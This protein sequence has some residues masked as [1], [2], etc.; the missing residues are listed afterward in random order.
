MPPYGNSY[1]ATDGLLPC[2]AFSL[3]P[4]TVKPSPFGNSAWY[5]GAVGDRLVEQWQVPVAFFQAGWSGTRMADWAESADHPSAPQQG[6]FISFPEG[7]PFGNLRVAINHYAT[8]FGLRAVLWHQGEMDTYANTSTQAYQTALQHTIGQSR[9][10]TGRPALAWVVARASRLGREAV[11]V[12]VLSAQNNVIASVPNV[13]AGPETDPLYGPGIREA[14]DVHFAGN[15]HQVAAQA[16]AATLSGSFLSATTP[17]EAVAPPPLTVA[18][19]GPSQLQLSGPGGFA[20]YRWLPSTNCQQSLSSGQTASF[21]PGSYVLQTRTAMGDV[22]LSATYQVPSQVGFAETISVSGNTPL[23]AG[24]TLRLTASVSGV[25]WS[26]PNGFSSTAQNPEISNISALQ[27][28]SYTATASNLYGCTGQGSLGVQVISQ[29]VSRQSG[30]WAEATTWEPN[31]AG[32][33]PTPATA[34]R[35]QAGH[36]VEVE[37]GSTAEARSLTLEGVLS[38]AGQLLLKP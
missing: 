17:Y 36:R 27:A 11:S 25:N 13:F 18:C 35:I 1:A 21:G 14:D 15:G 6:L 3:F 37:A 34:V 32:C 30:R 38:L 2:P 20:A 33:V 16:W 29:Y 12:S 19:Q 5:W 28:G 7:Q 23:S 4:A 24:S 22:G 10:Q 31:C 9:S 8:Q 26:G